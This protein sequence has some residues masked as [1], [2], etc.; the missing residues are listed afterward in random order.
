V[1]PAS[2]QGNNKEE[3]PTCQICQ[4][5]NHT[6]LTYLNRFNHAFSLNDVPQALAAMTIVDNQDSTW[7]PNTRATYYMT[8]D[9]GNLHSLTPYH[10]T[11]GVMVGNGDSLPITHIGQATIGSG[12]SSLKLNDV[13]LVPDIKKDLLSVSKLT[14][15]YPLI[16]EF[17]GDGFVI[18]DR[19]T[20]R[21]VATGSRRGGLYALDGGPAVFFSHRFRRINREGWHQRL[22]H[23][24]QRIVDHLRHRKLISFDSKNKTSKICTSCQMGKSCRLPF[25]SVDE[26]ITSPFYKVHCDLWGPA[27]VRSKEQF[28]FYAVFIDDYTRFSWFYPMRRKS[29]FFECFV[30]F[31]K[32]VTCQFDAKIRIFQSDEGGEFTAGSL[33]HYLANLG[34]RHQFAC[35]KTPEQ[36]GTAER[37]HRHITE[38]GLTMMFHARLP[39]RFWVECFS[40]AAFLIN[41]LPSPHLGMESPFFRLFGKHPDYSTFRVFGCKC[42]PYLGD[43]RHDK[44]SPKSLPCVFIGYSTTHKGYKCLYPPTGRIYTSHATLFLMRRYYLLQSPLVSMIMLPF[45]GRFARL[46][47]GSISPRHG[48]TS[49]TRFIFTWHDPTNK[50]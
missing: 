12:S 38:L 15:D 49:S 34:I 43:Y 47:I 41:R 20:N 30:H 29:D 26:S 18:K 8:G 40:T 45:K 21:I 1:S 48:P 32:F 14:S 42:F 37:K 31:Q 46:M 16:F 23:P 9:P 7:F 19:T 4:K 24:Q 22:G 3:Q 6:T 33:A 44:L 13:L 11:D 25:L 36:N 27:P 17:D 39:T 5:R 10:G 2:S 35:P 28:R 50:T